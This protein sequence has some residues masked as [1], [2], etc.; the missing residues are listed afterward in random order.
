MRAFDTV[1]AEAIRR[2]RGNP[3]FG[4]FVQWLEDIARDLK[5][6]AVHPDETSDRHVAGQAYGT[7]QIV[8]RIHKIWETKGSL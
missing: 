7:D 2:L 3:D 8:V 4:V 1:Q 5:S 6:L